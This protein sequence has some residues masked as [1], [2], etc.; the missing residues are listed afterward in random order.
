M[1]RGRKREKTLDFEKLTHIMYVQFNIELI[2][3]FSG[4]THCFARRH[5]SGAKALKYAAAFVII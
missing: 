4:C 2:N 1:P 5:I 3:N